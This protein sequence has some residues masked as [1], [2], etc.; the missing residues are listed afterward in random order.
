MKKLLALFLLLPLSGEFLPLK[1]GGFQI[2]Q[3]SAKSMAFGG[4]FTGFCGDASTV[5]YNPGGMNNL[6]GQN[7]T[8]GIIGLYPYV[9][10]QTP[11]NANIDQTSKVY[12]PIGIYY[13]GSFWDKVRIGMSINNQF[14]S[15]ASYPNVWE[16]QYIVQSIELK[17]YMFQPT[18]S[19][20]IIKQ[21][22]VGAG[23]VYTFGTFSD[24]KA[25]PVASNEYPYGEASLS[26]NGHAA[27][28]NLGL[29]SKIWEH[30]NDSGAHQSLQLGVSYR[31]ELKMTVPNGNVN[32]SQ[33]PTSLATE[34]PGSENFST[35][36]NMPAVFTAGFAFKFSCNK[37]W[38]FMV[39][40]D[41]DYTFWSA[42][43]S[44]HFNFSNTNTPSQGF[45]Y[46]W[47]NATA[48][49]MGAEATFMKKYSVRV[50]YYI[51]NTPVQ[52]GYVSPEIVDA[53]ATG[54]SVG[55]GVKFCK[56]YSVDLSYLRSD[57]TWNNTVLNTPDGTTLQ[58][59]AS[60]DFTA[61]YH[62][63]INMFGIGVNYQF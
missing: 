20:Q 3:Q 51:D 16:G 6:Y 13:V 41:F 42:Y 31:S 55:V 4:A 52:Q 36:L 18:V 37:N 23:F 60:P 43:D 35:N 1:A 39:T 7:F 38:D 62:R 50:G 49:R 54:F 9:S 24:T 32:F 14:G 59:G 33:I 25:I 15:S 22:S 48:H 40:Y 10:V 45:V 47:K 58:A 29:F 27:G 30:G 34:F 2:P 8:A 53:N 11:A 19:Y 12:T 26:G 21:L 28:Y 57:F 5:F 56:H 61:S 44:L 46:N 63:I 17:T